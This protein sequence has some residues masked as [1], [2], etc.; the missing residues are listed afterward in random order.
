MKSVKQ[1][2]FLL[3]LISIPVFL[4][5]QSLDSLTSIAVNVSP[6]LKML[7]AKAEAAA[8]RIEQNSNLPDPTLTL[9]VANLPVNTFSLTQ[10]PMTGKIVG[11]SQG[12]PFP[13]KLGTAADVASK[14]VEIVK[15]E[16]YD[17]KND[18]IKN[19]RQSYYELAY[20]RKAIAIEKESKKLLNDI[21]N[22]VRTRYEVSAASQQNLLKV[23]LELTN[24]S[25]KIED[26]KSKEASI[27]ADL[28][29]LLLLPSDNV[30]TTGEINGIEF[31]KYTTEELDSLAVENR[32][33][34][35]GFR[36]AQEKAALQENLAKYDRYPNFN[37][38]VQYSQRDEIA[39]TNTPL[40][41]FFSVMVGISLPL[42]YGGKTTARVQEAESMQ[43][44][45]AQQ[46]A[47]ARQVLTQNFGSSI[48]K[49]NS[50]KERIKLINEAEYPQAQQTFNS[51]LSSYQTGQIDFINVI[52]S[53]NKLYQV[54]TSL[55]R[56]ETDYLKEIAGL[57][58][59][60]GT[61]LKQNLE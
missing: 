22:V 50:I 52:D 23:Q 30:I 27:T 28:N 58:F 6:K 34:L 18:I 24:I 19:V 42:N 3:Y 9:G 4:Y 53:Q 48:A 43:E 57:E 45:Y 37:L 2:L 13:G 49:L 32:A 11:L 8:N 39:K 35:K 56:L 54:E 40:T 25:D 59:L 41:D 44:M 31:Q 46:Y 60:T 36:L 55:Y 21:S 38:S 10:E 16:Y 7:Q 15:Q 12:I 61:D 14:D 17:A 47:L 26:L 1:I 33:Y 20:T 51:A 5:G 29:A